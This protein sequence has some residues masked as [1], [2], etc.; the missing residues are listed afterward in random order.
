MDPETGVDVEPGTVGELWVN[1]SQNVIGG[2]L[3]TGDLARQDPDGYIYPSG[4]LKDTINRGGEK[5][6]PIEVEEALRTHPAVRDVAVAG[7]ADDE[8]GQRV[9]AAVVACSPVTLE[10]LR[11]ALSRA[12]RLFQASRADDHRRPDPVQRHR[13]GQPPSARRA[14]RGRDLSRRDGGAV[15]F[16]HETHKVVGARED[17][18]E[19]AYREGWMPTLAGEDERSTSLVHQ[20][21]PRLGAVLQRGHDHG[22][23]RR[24]GVGK[25]CPPRPD[26]G[27]AAV[28]ARAGQPAPRG[29][30]QDPA[31]GRVVAAAGGRPGDRA[32][33]CCDTSAESVHGGHRL[34][35]RTAGRL[36]PLV[37]RD[38]LPA[39]VHDHR[40][41]STSRHASRW[42]TGATSDARRCCGRRSTRP[43]TTRRSFAC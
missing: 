21:R 26:G 2:W 18:F 9:G 8:M 37:G 4:R 41:C 17:E 19:A 24:R 3:H 15:L 16:L 7:V 33:R 22:H 11:D 30:R 27:P 25:A 36:H 32:H 31:A 35:V 42:R 10:E 20:P 38:L 39:A 14:D 29:D 23:R 12:D 40:G 34:A 5:F 43:T 1:T 6:G 28:D 13:Q